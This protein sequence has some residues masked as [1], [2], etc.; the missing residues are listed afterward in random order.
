MAHSDEASKNYC[1]D[2]KLPSIDLLLLSFVNLPKEYNQDSP[3]WEQITVIVKSVV[4]IIIG[5][6]EAF[7]PFW[8]AET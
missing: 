2:V 6:S 1:F 3:S 5:A 4:S 7:L 8:K